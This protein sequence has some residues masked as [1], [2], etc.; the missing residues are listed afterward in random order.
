[1][2]C[3][4]LVQAHTLFHVYIVNAPCKIQKYIWT[5]H[6]PFSGPLF[7]ALKKKKSQFIFFTFYILIA[8]ILY[9]SPYPLP[10]FFSNIVYSVYIWTLFFL[11]IYIYIYIYIKLFQFIVLIKGG[12]HDRLQN[13]Q[14]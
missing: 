13:Y 7:S 10:F 1:M 3:P 5:K 4:F 8:M 2:S 14:T 9:L 11:C 6:V 12:R